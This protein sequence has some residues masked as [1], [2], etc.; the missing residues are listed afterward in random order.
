MPGL[1][2]A[3][4]DPRSGFPADPRGVEVARFAL[5]ADAEP[6]ILE[7]AAYSGAAW[8]ERVEGRTR[9]ALALIASAFSAFP[10]GYPTGPDFLRLGVECADGLGEA[11]RLDALLAAP[12]R[13]PISRDPKAELSHASLDL[14]RAGR[15]IRTGQIA[16]A[17]AL[18]RDSI[19]KFAAAGDAVRPP[20][21]RARSPTFCNRAASSTRPC[22]SA[23]RTNSRSTTASATS[24]SAP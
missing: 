18:T 6:A 24:A 10:D 22:V 11:A 19:V 5:A 17:E 8:L 4:H 14:R 21:R 23:A 15:L 12:V 1:I 3:W 2:A 16:K 20:S 7:D 9:E 13:P